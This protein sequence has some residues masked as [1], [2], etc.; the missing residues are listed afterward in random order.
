MFNSE[1]I[2]AWLATSSIIVTIIVSVWTLS[3]W[4]SSQFKDV[5]NLV[6][7]KVEQVQRIFLERL[8]HHERHDDKRFNEVVEDIWNIR[9]RNAARDGRP[10]NGIS[11]N[12][13]K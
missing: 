3:W 13:S 1:F 5:R 10:L 12:G 9:V 2:Q 11:N 4:L 7:D 8:E 6:Y